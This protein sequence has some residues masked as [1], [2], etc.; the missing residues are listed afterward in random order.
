MLFS[1]TVSKVEIF[2]RPFSWSANTSLKF[3]Y[4]FFSIF[5][6]DRI[7]SPSFSI[8]VLQYHFN[9]MYLQIF[10]KEIFLIQFW[11]RQ[12]RWFLIIISLQVVLKLSAKELILLLQ[13]INKF[14]YNNPPWEVPTQV[15]LGILFTKISIFMVW[16][17]IRKNIDFYYAFC[18]SKSWEN[19]LK[20]RTTF[21]DNI[22]HKNFD[23]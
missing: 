14:F 23:F 22:F 21:F 7:C 2:S 6:L 11:I 4:A 18:I 12:L 15:I 16:Q 10:P 13:K 3:P 1:I 19:Y 9:M 20:I 5:W 17:I 8:R